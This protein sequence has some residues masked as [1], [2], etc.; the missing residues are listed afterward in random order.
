MIVVVFGGA[1]SNVRGAAVVGVNAGQSKEEQVS[2][3]WCRVGGGLKT[4]QVLIDGARLVS[5]E[6]SWL[7]IEQVV[8]LIHFLPFI[9]A[10]KGDM[11]MGYR[12]EHG[13]VWTWMESW[14]LDDRLLFPL[15]G[16]AVQT[17]QRVQTAHGRTGQQT[18][19]EACRSWYRN[20]GAAAEH[21]T[22]GHIGHT[23]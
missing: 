4:Q 17:S 19:S 9:K 10:R 2:S 14:T 1:D 22:V 18:D 23:A 8:E 11:D 7:Q 5:S 3:R 20:L 12:D 16:Q 13:C 15:G 21:T 6:A